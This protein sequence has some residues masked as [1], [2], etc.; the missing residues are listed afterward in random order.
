MRRWLTPWIIAPLLALCGCAS[1]DPQVYQ[2]EQP[3]LDLFRYFDGTVDAWGYFSDRSGQ[4]V[5]RF[6]VVIQGRVQ[7]DV[8]TLEEDFHYSD[9]STSR[10]VWT[11]TRQNAN[12]F[13]GTAS[14]VVGQASGQRYGNA[15]H[16]TYVMAL[17]VD[18]TTYHVDFDDWMYLQ[19]D[20]VMLN[21]SVMR[22]FGFTLGEVILSFRKRP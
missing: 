17:P 5:K 3:T 12:S 22:K 20:T 2:A 10:R 1:V 16:W 11:I 4:V 7:G 21:K 15:L 13:I 19:D 6:K 8:L 9:G 14:D 18:G